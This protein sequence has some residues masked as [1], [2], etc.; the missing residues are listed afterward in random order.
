MKREAKFYNVFFPVWMVLLVP[1]PL[2]LLALPA[3][4]V[5]D[6]LV[7]TVSAKRQRPELPGRFFR[8][9]TWKL[10]LIGLG[11][12]LVGILF[13]LLPVVAFN[14]F[15]PFKGSEVCQEFVNWLCL[16]AIGD[17]WALGYTLLAIL[18]AGYLIYVGDKAILRRTGE[19]DATQAKKTAWH[20]AIFTA[21]Y[22]YLLPAETF[23]EVV[24]WLF[25]LIA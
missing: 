17:P 7:F 4:Y 5:I 1:S 22:L 16:Y 2:W 18:L 8:R 15:E 14:L 24:K 10:W 3:N 11:A 13:L 20:M 25:G 12:D 21:P 23:Q 19:L 9:H 6:R